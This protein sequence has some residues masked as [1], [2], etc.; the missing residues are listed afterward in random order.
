MSYRK[1][2]EKRRRG[3][4]F[5]KMPPSCNFSATYCNKHFHSRK[6]ISYCRIDQLKT[7]LDESSSSSDEDKSHRKV[8]KKKKKV[9]YAVRLFTARKRSLRRLCYILHVSVIHSVHGGGVRGCSGGGLGACAV[10]QGGAWFLWGGHAWLLPGGHAWLL[11]GG[12]VVAQ[13]VHGFSGGHAWLLLGGGGHAWLL[14]GGVREIRRDT[15][16]RSMSGR[17]ASYWNAFFFH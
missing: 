3:I 14:Q 4:I 6:Y 11:P 16:I 17:Y 1:R 8:K 12:C 15:Q 9:Y 10:A 7:L 13:G 2:K 5:L